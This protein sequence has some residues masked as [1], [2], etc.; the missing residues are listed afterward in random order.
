MGTVK[1][2]PLLVGTFLLVWAVLFWIFGG[3]RY[4]KWYYQNA[5]YSQDRDYKKYDLKR[6]KAV[7]AITAL[8]LA[9]VCIFLGITEKMLFLWILVAVIVIRSILLDTVCKRRR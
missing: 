6:F 2:F 4:M 7:Q 3:G 8:F 5:W 9:S 1:L